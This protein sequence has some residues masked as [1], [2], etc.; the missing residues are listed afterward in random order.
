MENLNMNQNLNSI[1]C[2]FYGIFKMFDSQQIIKEFNEIIKIISNKKLE[3]GELVQN[4]FEK[5]FIIPEKGKQTFKCKFEQKESYYLIILSEI[6]SEN[7]EIEKY[8]IL[9]KKVKYKFKYKEINYCCFLVESMRTFLDSIYKINSFH[10]AMIN[11][12]NNKGKIVTYNEY[13]FLYLQN[14]EIIIDYQFKEISFENITYE[15]IYKKNT[16]IKKGSDLNLKLGLYVKLNQQQFENFEYFNSLQRKKLIK[17]IENAIGFLKYFGI[18]GPYGTGKTIT[19]LKLIIES[20]NQNFLYIN[21]STINNNHI[22]QIKEIIRYELIKLFGSDIFNYNKNK[23]TTDNKQLIYNKIVN[24]IEIFDN[25]KDIFNLIKKIMSLCKDLYKK[26]FIYFIIDQYSSKFDTNNDSIKQLINETNEFIHLIICSSMNNY[27]VKINLC[28][29]FKENPDNSSNLFYF[30]VGTIIKLNDFNNFENM[31]KDESN[32]F[33][34]ILYNFGY[35]PLYYYNLNSLDKEKKNLEFF[36]N[37]EKKRIKEEI[38]YFYTNDETKKDN[39]IT[40]QMYKDILKILHII[41]NKTIYFYNELEKELLQFPLKFLEIKKEELELED[42]E[43]YGIITKNNKINN[44]FK[45]LKEDEGMLFDLKVKNVEVYKLMNEENYCKNYISKISDNK[46]NRI[47]QKTNYNCKIT[48]FYLDYLFPLIEDIFSSLIYDTLSQSANLIYHELPSQSQGGL[49]EYIIYEKIKNSKD[50]LNYYIKKIEVIDNFV[51]N[52]FFIQ[53]YISRKIDTIKTYIENNN[54]NIINNSLKD[55]TNCKIF[56]KQKQFTGKYYDCGLLVPEIKKNEYKLILFQ[57]SKKKISSQRYFRE[58]HQLIFKRVKD[59]MEK[60]YDIIINNGYFSYILLEEEKDEKTIN[61]CEI[62][63]IN[64]IFFSILK[65]NFSG[66]SE[67]DSIFNEKTFITNDFPLH[68]SFSILSRKYFEI[69][70]NILINYSYIKNIQKSLMLEEISEEKQKMLNN[71][72]ILK[73]EKDENKNCFYIY[74]HFDKVF[75]TNSSFCRWFNNNN[76]LFYYYN[77]ELK[78]EKLEFKITSKF[79]EKKKFTL[80]CSKFKIK[81]NIKVEINNLIDNYNKINI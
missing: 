33:K 81:N 61:F 36:L 8:K 72:F 56:L 21:L 19:L 69:K 48:I 27:S 44:F 76:F 28:N 16:E 7:E 55:L 22:I 68:N 74:G 49:I 67:R 71:Y 4:E 52:T 32:E 34:E 31:I 46:R 13:V 26:N 30:Y 15:D 45:K 75:E 3:K 17:F 37:E 62:N 14:F 25:K 38:K 58:E 64:Y 1:S 63:G 50:F 35:F 9:L 70:N 29:S 78:L 53:N 73:H 24:L 80:I 57:I 23:K 6:F 66:F 11:P 79:S 42:L 12:L 59:N 54:I 20:P 41:N 60:K 77:K 5:I 43:L 51:P 10:I 2:K 40:I 18:C 65:M 39:E 47:Y